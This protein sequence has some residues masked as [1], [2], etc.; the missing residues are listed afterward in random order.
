MAAMS[1]KP[2]R[3]AFP[4]KLA[5]PLAD[6]VKAEADARGMPWSEYIATIFAQAHGFE[7]SPLPERTSPVPTQV[8]INLHLPS[9]QQ[10]QQSEAP[11]ARR[12]PGRPSRGKRWPFKVQLPIPQAD[13]VKTEADARNMPWAEYIAITVAQAHAVDI[14]MPERQSEP[15]DQALPSLKQLSA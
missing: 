2:K 14:P 4:V 6:L 7:V 10:P 12:G 8:A 3:W 11:P 13:F 15:S 5:I 1:T 9:T